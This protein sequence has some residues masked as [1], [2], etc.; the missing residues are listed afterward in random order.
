MFNFE[1]LEVRQKATVYAGPVYYQAL[2]AS[3]EEISRMLSGR[4]GSLGG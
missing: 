1:R 3:G 2:H 4:R